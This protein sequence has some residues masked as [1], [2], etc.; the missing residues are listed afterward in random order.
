MKVAKLFMVFVS[1]NPARRYTLAL[2]LHL[3]EGGG[4]GG[5]LR[6]DIPIIARPKE[7]GGLA[8]WLC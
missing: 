2:N 1:G 7:K 6:R 4:G 5:S 3:H 8:F